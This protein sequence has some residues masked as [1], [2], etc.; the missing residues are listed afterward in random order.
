LE[1]V[2]IAAIVLRRH[3]HGDRESRHPSAVGSSAPAR[4]LLH[5]HDATFVRDAAAGTRRF[6]LYIR[7]Q[8]EVA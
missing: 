5:D 4:A 8:I 3:C 1:V 6:N 2:P 7:V